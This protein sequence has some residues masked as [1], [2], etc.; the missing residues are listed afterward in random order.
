MNARYNTVLRIHINMGLKLR[1]ISFKNNEIPFITAFG[2]P[3][4][5]KS[6]NDQESISC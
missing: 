5:R 6:P 3:T 1:K 2:E 4:L